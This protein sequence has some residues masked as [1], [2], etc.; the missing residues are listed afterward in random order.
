[1][2]GG[3]KTD[4]SD[5]LV[6][7]V[8]S[9]KHFI[10]RFNRREFVSAIFC[11]FPAHHKNCLLRISAANTRT[12]FVYFTFVGFFIEVCTFK[13]K[14]DFILACDI[15]VRIKR[16]KK[17]E[18][19]KFVFGLYYVFCMPY[20]NLFAAPS[21]PKTVTRAVVCPSQEIFIDKFLYTAKNFA[22]HR[23]VLLQ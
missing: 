16:M 19:F 2:V 12:F 6:F 20:V 7:F 11:Q 1:M 23:T 3:I 4:F 8:K 21:A 10:K 15:K 9:C 14:S 22:K 13:N 17:S 5:L 18:F